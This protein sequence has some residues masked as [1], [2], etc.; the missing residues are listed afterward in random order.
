MKTLEE[1]LREG[2]E[3][4]ASFGHCWVMGKGNERILWN[5]RTREIEFKYER[6]L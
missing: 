6:S 4:I 2:W 1:L 5:P 3:N